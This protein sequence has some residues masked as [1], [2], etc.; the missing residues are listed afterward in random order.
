MYDSKN[1]FKCNIHQPLS[2]FYKHKAMADGHLNKCKTC[3]K[4][5]VSKNRSEN[6]DYYLEYD[7]ARA[8]VQK[9]V[10]ARSAYSKT[11][12]GM[13]A[14]RIARQKWIDSNK[15]KRAAQIMVGNAVKSGR[16]IKGV[17][18]ECCGKT[19][20]RLNGHHDDYAKPLEVRYLCSSCHCKWHKENGEGLNG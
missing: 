19:N 7:R 10:D 3:T 5:D 1:C 14:H 8:N 16:L 9:R 18:C 6:I 17:S 15:I 20:L 12:D 13:A 2:E 11:E 4:I